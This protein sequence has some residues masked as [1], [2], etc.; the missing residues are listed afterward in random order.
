[1]VII[2]NFFVNTYPFEEGNDSFK[3]TVSKRS[4]MVV[5]TS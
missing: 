3:G 2:L 5:R 1:M 4:F